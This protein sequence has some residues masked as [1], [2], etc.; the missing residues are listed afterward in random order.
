MTNPEGVERELERFVVAESTRI[1]DDCLAAIS[2]I[3]MAD[4]D[5]LQLDSLPIRVILSLRT[6]LV[7]G[8]EGF[9]AYQ[10]PILIEELQR[11]ARPPKRRYR[12]S[13]N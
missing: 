12:I 4:I 9:V 1:H 10:L 8:F 6:N 2:K 13:Q 7:H 5:I 3:A 11:R